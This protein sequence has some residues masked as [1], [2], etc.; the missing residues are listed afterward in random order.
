M[1]LGEGVSGSV[2]LRYMGKGW[3]KIDILRYI[4]YGRPHTELSNS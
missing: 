2:L 4:I 3:Q 1:I